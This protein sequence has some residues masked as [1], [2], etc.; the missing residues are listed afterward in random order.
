MCVTTGTLVLIRLYKKADLLETKVNSTKGRKVGVE[1]NNPEKN[2][3][4][5]PS[6][7]GGR[8]VVVVRQADNIL[9]VYKKFNII[10]PTSIVKNI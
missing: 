8:S 4:H 6:S 9:A 7:L 5:K 2:G 1:E 10:M 3:G